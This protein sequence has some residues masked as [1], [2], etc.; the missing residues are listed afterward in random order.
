MNFK[1]LLKILNYFHF[2]NTYKEYFRKHVFLKKYFQKKRNLLLNSEKSQLLL[3]RFINK[4]NDLD[5]IRKT[6]FNNKIFSYSNDKE[7]KDILEHL[8]INC[9]SFINRYLEHAAKILRKEFSIFEKSVSFEKEIDWHYSFF[10]KY[11]W[12]FRIA[13][14]INIRPENQTIDVKYVWELNRHQFLT[15]LGFA[16]YYTEKEKYASIFREF[17]LDWIKKNPPFIGINWYSSL[18]IS[19][20]LT[21]WI[22]SLIFFKNSKIINN[23]YF[24]EKI[25]HSMLQHAYYLRFF[26]FRRSFNHTIGDIFGIYLLSK[27]F[28]NIKP[29]KKWSKSFRKKLIKQIDLQIRLDGVNIE[30]S[31]NYHRFVLEFFTLFVL[32]EKNNLKDEKKYLIEK[33]YDYLL[34]IIKPNKNLPLIGDSDD[35]KVLLL[36]FYDT[37]SYLHLLNLG[38]I[39]FKRQDLKYISRKIS[40]ISILLLGING[41]IKYNKLNIQKPKD[42]IKHFNKSGYISIRNNWSKHGNYL[43][44]DFGRFGP[45]HAPHS[46]SGITNIIFTYN[47][48]DILIDSGTY[49]YNK[50]WNERNLHRS[51]KAH[52]ILMINN[53][54]QAKVLSWFEWDK[55]PKIK[56]NIKRNGN[57]FKFSCIHDGYKGYLVKRVIITRTNL[58]NLEIRDFVIPYDLSN[59][60][61][62]LKISI[63]FH[64]N[65]DVNL[66]IIDN[67]I[68]I[69]NEIKLIISSKHLFEI[70]EEEFFYS[71]HYGKKFKSNMISINLKVKSIN[72]KQV[73]VITKLIKI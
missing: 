56:R 35:G 38:S 4:N 31:V 68:M 23:N 21:S 17:I 25:F 28:Y 7:K 57:L 24:F 3:K 12:P 30:Q 22:F 51:S 10:D 2:V 42:L 8:E 54:N 36:T 11:N 46:H 19:L 50:S 47:G 5:K 62:A 37:E 13:D 15:Y 60:G 49:T 29:F 48:Q 20:R 71:P 61:K 14:E 67:Q 73:E 32:I 39:I 33:M 18:E 66:N 45:Q 41:I 64:F 43:F 27:I 72:F 1:E 9:K 63:F 69:N 59:I 53:K 34:Y 58:D 65:D 52:N 6:F 40:P 44:I 26:Y 55:K 70:K 16:Y